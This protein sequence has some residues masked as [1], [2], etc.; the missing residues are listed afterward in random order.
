MF[1]FAYP[2]LWCFLCVLILSASAAHERHICTL[3]DTDTDTGTHTDTDTDTDTD[4]GRETC[5]PFRGRLPVDCC[6]EREGERERVAEAAAVARVCEC[7][8]VSVRLVRSPAD[9]KHPRSEPS[10]SLERND[11]AR[12]SRPTSEKLKKCTRKPKEFSAR[13]SET[14]PKDTTPNKPIPIFAEQVQQV[15]VKCKCVLTSFWHFSSCQNTVQR[16]SRF[17]DPCDSSVQSLTVDSASPE[18]QRRSQT[19]MRN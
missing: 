9:S 19:D 13:E 8:G 1:A 17:R 11:R 2:T 18:S 5:T 7:L 10:H 12:L 3:A 15:R 16:R 4:T 6:P 14:N